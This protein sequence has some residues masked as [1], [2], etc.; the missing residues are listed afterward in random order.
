MLVSAIALTVVCA[1]SFAVIPALWWMPRNARMRPRPD[2]S[3]ALT[4]GRSAKPS[5]RSPVA[6]TKK[7]HN[8]ASLEVPT[9][10]RAER[11]PQ[12]E[13]PGVPPLLPFRLARRGNRLH[14]KNPSVW[15]S[16][17]ARGPDGHRELRRCRRTS[18]G[19]DGEMNRIARNSIGESR[20]WNQPQMR[21]RG[22][23]KDSGS[24]SWRCGRRGRWLAQ[25][26]RTGAP[27]SSRSN[28][29][30]AIPFARSIYGRQGN[31]DRDQ[32]RV[33]GQQSRQTQYRARRQDRGRPAHRA[34]VDPSG[35][36]LSDQP[37]LQRAG[38]DGVGLCDRQQ[39]RARPGVLPCH[40]LRR[41]RRMARQGGLRRRRLFRAGR[42]RGD[43]AA[44]GGRADDALR[45]FRRLLHRDDRGGWR[46]RGA[47][48][49]PANR[50]GPTGGGVA[51]ARGSLRDQR[52]S[53]PRYSWDAAAGGQIA[54]GNPQPDE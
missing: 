29:P 48:G 9:L 34:R 42:C 31:R 28:R 41:R 18:G 2:L 15:D 53:G 45:R 14:G 47:A 19:A 17:C 39:D 43:A 4:A 11:T 35:G 38:A 20:Q 22:R 51:A 37:A 16:I 49:A 44:A 52:A 32:P 6:V 21:P 25:S 3:G 24:S 1:A 5:R 30:M 23:S 13:R 10:R 36:R 27:R 8:G 7:R 26:W 46:L 50:A 12:T 33:P 40:R 54:S